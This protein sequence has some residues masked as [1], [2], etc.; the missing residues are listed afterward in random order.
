VTG[1]RPVPAPPPCRPKKSELFV[2]GAL[3]KMF[4]VGVKCVALT[5]CDQFLFLLFSDSL[6]TDKIV[7][8]S[9]VLCRGTNLHVGHLVAINDKCPWL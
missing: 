7:A 1:T 6:W 9:N 5:V 3:K 8:L 4:M 2:L